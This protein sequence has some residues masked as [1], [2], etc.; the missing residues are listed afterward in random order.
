[1]KSKIL[2][3]LAVGL[4]AAPMA[5]NAAL[6][7]FESGLDPAFTYVE[8]LAFSTADAFVIGGG[9]LNVLNASSSDGGVVNPS[10]AS[11][12]DFLWNS[13]GTFD[14]TSFLIAGAWGSQTLTIQGWN[15]GVL[16]QSTSL[17]VTTDPI[18]FT[19]NWVGLDQ[20]RILTDPNGYVDAGLAG[21]GQ[22]WA[23][24]N[25]VIN[26][27]T[28]PEPGTLALLGLGLVGMGYA[29]RRKAS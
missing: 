8:V 28:V 6:I 18:T 23:L 1:M 24:D 16:L 21:F 25:L 10:E 19:A 13:P 14:L 5:A 26:S 22:H 29:R 11:P 17:F 15:D 12:S 27:A 20:L 9:Y 2:G 7:D 4:L 3:L